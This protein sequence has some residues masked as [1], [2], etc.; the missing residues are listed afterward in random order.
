MGKN[1]NFGEN[2]VKWESKTDKEQIYTKRGKG[3]Q[4]IF[5]LGK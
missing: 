2:N 3:L 5:K 1:E 4:N